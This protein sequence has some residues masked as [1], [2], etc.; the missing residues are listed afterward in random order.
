MHVLRKPLVKRQ[1]G[2]YAGFIVGHKDLVLQPEAAD[3]LDA[4]IR[5]DAEEHARSQQDK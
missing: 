2:E 5:F 3:P 4:G 1:R